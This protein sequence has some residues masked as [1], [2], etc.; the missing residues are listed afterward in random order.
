MNE[1]Q[2]YSIVRKFKIEGKLDRTPA[3]SANISKFQ[4]NVLSKNRKTEQILS[5]QGIDGHSESQKKRL[6]PCSEEE[7]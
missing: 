6:N 4:N 7:K 5:R 2:I 3:E 1:L